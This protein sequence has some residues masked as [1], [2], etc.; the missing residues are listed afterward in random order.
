MQ[1]RLHMNEKRYVIGV[2]NRVRDRAG[3]GTKVRSKL[4]LYTLH[5]ET[6]AVLRHFDVIGSICQAVLALR[7]APA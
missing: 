5:N 2:R 4:A 1:C 3:M 6:C 7:S